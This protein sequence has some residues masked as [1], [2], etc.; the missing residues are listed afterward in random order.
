M[1]AFVAAMRE[2]WN[3]GDFEA[4]MQYHEN[5]PETLLIFDQ[6]VY[7]GWDAVRELYKN[8]FDT[9]ARKGEVSFSNERV[10]SLS[11]NTATLTANWCLQSLEGRQIGG[12]F[13]L[14]LRRNAE[15]WRIV[16][17]HSATIPQE[18]KVE[19]GLK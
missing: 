5:S 3:T 16:V 13:T 11:E 17:D 9:G 7:E 18:Q 1:V 14:A 12:I 4:Y 10:F 2:A 6:N 19:V 15:G 8:I